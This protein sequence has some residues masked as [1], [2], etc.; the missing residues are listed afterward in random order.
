MIRASRSLT[1]IQV[2]SLASG[3]SGNAMLVRAGDT[4]ILIDAGLT[5]RALANALAKK[6]VAASDLHGIL[7]THEHSDHSCGAGGLAR[8]HNTPI[9]ANTATFQAYTQRDALPFMAKELATG[10]T[11]AIGCIGI[12]SFAVSHDAAEPVGYVLNIGAT[13]ITYFTDTGCVTEAIREAVKGAD[14]AIVEANH[15]LDWLWRGPYPEHR[16]VRVASDT[17]HLSNA[18]CGDLLAERLEDR[19]ALSVW[20]AHI[21]RVNNSPALAKRS[22]QQRVAQQTRVP[23]TL[24]SAL[25]DQPSI[26][27]SPCKQA[28]QLALL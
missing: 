5:V 10:G 7:L 9:V 14:L 24:E 13:Q 26:S 1:S 25:H 12:R 15:D 23:F 17:G 20:L 27:W 2:H 21:S 6:G 8:R 4:N 11:A 18:S 22:I 16:K 3:S 28:V 19:G